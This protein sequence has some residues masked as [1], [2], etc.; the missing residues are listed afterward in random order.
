MNHRFLGATVALFVGMFLVYNTLA[1]TVAERRHDIGIMRALGATR[2]QI[3]GVFTM[4]ALLLGFVGST[5]GLAG[6]LA[7]ASLS[8]ETVRTILIE[9]FST[10]EL[11]ELSIPPTTIALA[12]AAGMGASLVASLRPSAA[13]A[14]EPPSNALRR[15]PIFVHPFETWWPLAAALLLA[16]SAVILNQQRAHFAPR[17]ATY[18]SLYLVGLAFMLATPF[19]ARLGV[20]LLRPVAWLLGTGGRLAADDLARSPGRTGLTVGK[21]ALG[22]A[23]TIQTAGIITSTKE[24]IF[25]WIERA[26]AAN[27]FVTSGSAITAGGGHTLMDEALGAKIAAHPDVADV[28]PVRLRTADFAATQIRICALPF[29]TYGRH[30]QVTLSDGDEADLPRLFEV[31]ARALL[32]SDNFAVQHGTRVGDMLE[33]NT[34]KHGRLAWRVIGSV[35]DYSWNRGTIFMDRAVYVTWFDDPMVDSYDLYVREGADPAAVRRELDERLGGAHQLVILDRDQFAQHIHHMIDQFYGLIYANA[36]MALAVSFLGV[37]NTLAIS[38]LQRRRE[39]GLLRAVGATRWQVAWSVAAQAL[40]I[41]ILGLLLG[42]GLG[43]LMQEFV[44]KVLMVEET[45]YFFAFI[46]PL[47]MTLATAAFALTAAQLAGAI[48]ALRAASQ[49]I[50]EAVAYE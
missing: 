34:G 40:L 37:A 13:A 14:A 24:P 29:E 38:V 4:E 32:I 47:T 22:L 35:R 7:L 45:G 36:F 11:R 12:L 44:L 8:M 25:S 19:L 1:V 46:F 10:I 18:V 43:A 21:L 3:R 27:L 30:N 49:P 39:L 16:A 5:L 41:G 42:V 23:M 15:V 31:K 50:S 6:G 48:P 9:Q 20:A 17:M 28:M 33:L 26:I 2:G